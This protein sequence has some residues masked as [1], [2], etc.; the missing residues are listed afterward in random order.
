[1]AKIK[2]TSKKLAR[3][4]SKVLKDAKSTK[5]AKR[6]AKFVSGKSKGKKK[7]K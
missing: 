3:A 7:K 5:A 4:A 6:I 1:M 2:K